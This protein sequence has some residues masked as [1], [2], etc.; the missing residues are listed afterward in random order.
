MARLCIFLEDDRDYF[1]A[2][3][4]DPDANHCKI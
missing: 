3:Y 4:L 2:A 1:H